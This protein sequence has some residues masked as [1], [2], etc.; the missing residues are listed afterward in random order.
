MLYVDDMLLI[1]NSVK[2]VNSVKSLLAKKFEMK[3]LGPANFI[4]GMQIRRDREK[5]KLWLG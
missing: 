3:D 5:Q 1:G 4:L 2:M